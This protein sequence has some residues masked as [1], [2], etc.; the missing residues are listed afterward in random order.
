[1]IFA[2]LVHVMLLLTLMVCC[3]WK[4]IQV[5][6]CCSRPSERVIF[7]M[8]KIPNFFYS[9]MPINI[10]TFPINGS[11]KKICVTSFQSSHTNTPNSYWCPNYCCKDCVTVPFG[12][13]LFVFFER[14]DFSPL[15]YSFF[16]HFLPLKKCTMRNRVQQ[17]SSKGEF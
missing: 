5:F 13:N 11:N 4:K 2:H 6:V 12:L 9:S 7:Q 10:V 14:C 1:M 15:L 3:P 16:F 17:R 8:A